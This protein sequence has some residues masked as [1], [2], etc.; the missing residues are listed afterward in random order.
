M[1][2]PRLLP[3]LFFNL[4]SLCAVEPLEYAPRPNDTYW[5]EEW[6]LE[7]LNT[8]AARLGIDI[9]AREAWA[10]SRGNGITIAI[11][12]N[13]VDLDHPE[14]GPRA[15]PALH[16]NFQTQQTNGYPLSDNWSHGTSVA[17][18]A[19]AAGNNNR[20]VIG[21]APEARFAS[22][23]IFQ[24]NSGAFVDSDA[25]AQMFQSH[26]EDVQVQNHS[27]VK[28]GEQ[29]TFMSGTESNAIEKAVT[30]GRG[31]RGVIIVRAAGNDRVAGRNV[32]DDAYT[33]DPRVTAVAAARFDGRTASYSTPGAPILVST[34]SGDTGSGFPN[35]FTTDRLGAKGFNQIGFTNDLADYV[36]AGLGFGGTS[37]SAPILS[38][39]GALIL[40]VNPNLTYRDVQQIFILAAKQTQPTD[41][42][43]HVNGAGLPVNHN[44]GF[45][46]VDAGT[47]VDLARHW[48]LRPAATRTSV[49]A[50]GDLN[51]PDAG[52][53][54]LLT[55]AAVP[56]ELT[57]IPALPS[58]GLHPDEPTRVLPL[59]YVGTAVNPLD[60][61][62]AGKAALIR[63]GGGDFALKIE[64]A[65]RAGAEFAIVYNN[66]GTNTLEVMGG[67]DFVPIPAV[68]VSQMHGEAISNIVTSASAQAQLKLETVQY[69]FNVTESLSCEQVRVNLTFMQQSRGD[70]RVTLVSPSGTRS[71]LARLGPDTQGF[72]GAWS[73]MST[74]HFYESSQ[75]KWQIFFS[76]EAVGATGIV[77]SATLE[78]KGVPI[79]DLD[80]DGLP[81]DW[82]VTHLLS[83]VSGP[84][85]D[86]DKDGYSNL[87]EWI[88]GTDPA[89]KETEL[90]LKISKWSDDIAR[91]NFPSREGVQYE[92]LG[93]DNLGQN[94]SVLTNLTG[95]FPRTPWFARSTSAHRFF[96]V[97]EK[98]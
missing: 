46:V 14:L 33:A 24:T 72:D 67:T 92:V 20:G 66:Q 90:A 53:K 98:Q 59:V 47:A 65:A 23:I 11:V 52:L 51:I 86:P 61:N 45:G 76:D 21:V 62:L 88:M 64:N 19:A 48:V 74:H 12:D 15:N 58:L 63:R 50:Q 39:I 35:L 9:N 79:L 42:D 41:P 60:T 7:N 17:G 55:G 94:L 10:Y 78:I 37:A 83:L 18:L 34:P 43:M 40:S 87:R 6:H 85:D 5:W 84:Q 36:F 77:H 8:N 4:A 1:N 32:N 95:E 29:F 28:P 27:W 30:Q 96:E 2:W 38:G 80:K 25:L 82:E 3:F 16:F 89:A 70:M 26:L 56:A 31:G 13:G 69:D 22:W 54:V 49:T 71:V 93:T 57:S 75:G 44:T 73:Y 81:D 91:S 68:F 97:R